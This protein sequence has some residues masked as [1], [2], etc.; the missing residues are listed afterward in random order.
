VQYENIK[1]LR[2]RFFPLPKSNGERWPNLYKKIKKGVETEIREVE[3]GN[4]NLRW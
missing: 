1:D 4:E 2:G 3:S